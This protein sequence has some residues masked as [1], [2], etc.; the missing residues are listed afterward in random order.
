MTTNAKKIILQFQ[1]NYF[2]LT[3]GMFVLFNQRLRLKYLTARNFISIQ[4]KN[5]RLFTE[6]NDFVINRL[7]INRLDT[8]LSLPLRKN[9][10][11]NY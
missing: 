2:C 3:F 9:K 5:E 1:A 6:N 4:A 7:E 10:L 11:Q 8:L